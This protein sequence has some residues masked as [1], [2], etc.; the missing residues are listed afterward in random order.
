M[1]YKP[2][3]ILFLELVLIKNGKQEN[4]VRLKIIEIKGVGPSY[5]EKLESLNIKTTY[6]LLKKCTTPQDRRKISK[7]SKISETIILKWVNMIDLLRIKGIGVEISEFMEYLGTDT[8]NKLAN[9]DPEI[10]FQKMKDLNNNKN[11][12]KRTPTLR[13]VENWI[14]Q[15]KEIPRIVKYFD[16]KQTETIGEFLNFE[17]KILED[18]LQ[19]YLQRVRQKKSIVKRKNQHL[20]EIFS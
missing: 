19:N 8:I 5:S 7:K 16:D 1:N 18:N 9:S 3:T 10:L 4:L 20:L 6:D 11:I 15:A 13:K 17:N 12:I 2:F 14:S